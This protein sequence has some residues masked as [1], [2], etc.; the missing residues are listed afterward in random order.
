MLS[1]IR[2]LQAL[3]NSA[4]LG[5]WLLLKLL[6]GSTAAVSETCRLFAPFI[7]EKASHLAALVKLIITHTLVPPLSV[8]PA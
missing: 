5:I 8:L 2:N 6:R 3:R 1:Y 7:R 4:N